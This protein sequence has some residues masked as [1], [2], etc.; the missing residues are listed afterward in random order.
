MVQ[1]WFNKKVMPFFTFNEGTV[2]DNAIAKAEAQ[3]GSLL[4]TCTEG[5][6][7]RK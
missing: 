3:Y 6:N 4:E 1:G 7:C 2:Y 5:T